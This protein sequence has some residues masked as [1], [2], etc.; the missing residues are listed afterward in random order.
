MYVINNL[1]I[2]Y[3]VGDEYSLA[4]TISEFHDFLGME[5]WFVDLEKAWSH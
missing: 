4:A 2:H 1:I 3:Q 5:L